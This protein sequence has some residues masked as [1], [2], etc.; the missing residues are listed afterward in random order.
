VWGEKGKKG[1]KTLIHNKLGGG[2][3]FSTEGPRTKKKKKNKGGSA[4]TGNC[5]RKRATYVNRAGG[6]KKKKKKKRNQDKHRRN[7]AKGK[8]ECDYISCWKKGKKLHS[9]LKRAFWC[10]VA[11]VPGEMWGKRE[12]GTMFSPRKEVSNCHPSKK[13]EIAS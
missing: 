8:K 12:K 2:G 3:C 11:G 6:E 5:S 13:K 1:K 7:R 10:T 9:F 4:V